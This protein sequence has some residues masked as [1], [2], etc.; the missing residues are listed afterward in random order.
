MKIKYKLFPEGLFSEIFGE[1]VI[2]VAG[3][4]KDKSPGEMLDLKAS[5]ESVLTT[6]PLRNA[7][8]V[9][10]RFGLIDASSLST[11]EDIGHQFGVTAER[12]RQMVV[13][14]L[15]LLRHPDRIRKLAKL[16][17]YYDPAKEA[18]LLEKEEA[19]R[20]S[21]TNAFATYGNLKNSDVEWSFRTRNVLDNHNIITIGDLCQ[22]TDAEM[23]KY[24]NFGRKS[25]LE[26]REKLAGF[27][28]RLGLV[29]I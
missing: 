16:T 28:L 7:G 5:V 10:C 9:R 1:P 18:Q 26:V 2:V 4:F 11:Y 27:G 14:G 6:L 12:G 17:P 15:R 29:F 23:M 25:L 13:K 21:V 8:A 19:A 22:K 24:R 20:K 3:W